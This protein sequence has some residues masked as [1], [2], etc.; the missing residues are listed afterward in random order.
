MT[1][2]DPPAAFRAFMKGYGGIGPLEQRDFG[3]WLAALLGWF[4]F[5]ARRTLGDWP[6]E[7]TFDRLDAQKMARDTL[8]EIERALTSMTLWT[9]WA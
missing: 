5:Q 3:K 7:T 8:L 4:S 1:A 2:L 6:T 9:S